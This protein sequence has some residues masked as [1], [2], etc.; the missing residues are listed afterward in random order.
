MIIP[1]L[2]LLVYAYDSS[3]PTHP[4]A[5]AWWRET[6]SGEEPV[7]LPRVV[8][9]GFV[10]VAT[11]PRVFRHP[12]TAKEAA[13]HVRSWLAQESVRVLNPGPDHIELVLKLLEAVGV[14]GNL[15][16]D[17]QVAALAIENEGVVLTADADFLRFSG[18]RWQNPLTGA[19]SR[20]PIKKERRR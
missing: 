8:I 2:N 5:A 4:K 7:G 17:A 3:S 12:M 18:V 10:R 1:D 13:H 14:A 20:G 19:A 9:F 6:L 16:T 11:N 15:V